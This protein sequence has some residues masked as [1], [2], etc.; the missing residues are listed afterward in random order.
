MAER[1]MFA[2]TIVTSDVFL[3][4]PLSA[5]C[6]YFTLGMFADDD[7]FVNNPKSIMRQTGA[8]IDDLNILLVR[9]FVISFESGIIVIRHWKINNYLRN[10]R[11]KE[12]ECLEEKS[13]LC[14]DKNGAYV[15]ADAPL[16]Y[17]MD[18]QY[19]IGKDSIEKEKVKKEKFVPP[20]L[21]EVR[22]YAKSKDRLDLA[23]RFFEYF[24]EG[25]WID[26]QGKHVKNWKQKF[27]TWKNKN[28]KQKNAVQG[29][30]YTSTDYKNMI[31]SI[32][33]IEL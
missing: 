18:T 32:D 24:E 29:R 22:E 20:T 4:M 7:G 10:D 17:Q 19:S 26:S 3:D 14:L 27:C 5:R 2:K 23:D 25:K 11:Y 13:Q 12:T 16:V 30:E 15:K 9:K 21:E 8:S 28:P 1:R 31:Q 33:E 6:L